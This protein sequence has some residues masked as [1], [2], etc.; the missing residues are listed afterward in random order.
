[1]H[2]RASDLLLPLQLWS[3]SSQEDILLTCG[4]A[5]IWTRRVISF[6]M[7]NLWMWFWFF[8]LWAKLE[9]RSVQSISKHVCMHIWAGSLVLRGVGVE[10]VIGTNH[11]FLDDFSLMKRLVVCRSSR[12]SEISKIFVLHMQSPPSQKKIINIAFK[13]LSGSFHCD[14]CSILFLGVLSRHGRMDRSWMVSL[15]IHF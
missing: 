7:L 1:M 2:S 12:S 5:A 15:D 8:L 6:S 9:S 11:K 10:M 13:I 3:V 14:V 4:L